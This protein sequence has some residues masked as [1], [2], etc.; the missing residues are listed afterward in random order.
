MLLPPALMNQSHEFF[1]VSVIDPNSMTYAP[2]NSSIV[3]SWSFSKQLN[4]TWNITGA[5]PQ[6]IEFK[7]NFSD[8]NYLRDVMLDDEI[9]VLVR[10][11]NYSNFETFDRR[12]LRS[13]GVISNFTN[14]LEILT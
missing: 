6:E 8:F 13:Q 3:N 11:S 2:K 4:F 14:V 7:L 9:Y 12:P 1:N 10:F 5:T